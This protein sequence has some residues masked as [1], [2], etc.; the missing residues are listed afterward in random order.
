MITKL[1]LLG[2]GDIAIRL[3]NILSNTEM[4]CYGMRRDISKL[5]GNIEGIQQDFTSLRGFNRQLEKGFDVVVITLVPS[6]RSEEAYRKMYVESLE[7]M[8]R[9]L[10]STTISPKFVLFVS[11]TS[12]YAQNKG[13][14]ISELSPTSPVT[15]SGQCIQSAETCILSSRLSSTVV[16][17]SGIYGPGRRRL[18]QQVIDGDR[19]ENDN[20][21]SNRIHAD[22]C[23]EVLGHLIKKHLNDQTL[24]K[25][26]LATDCQPVKTKQVKQWLA[27]TMGLEASSSQS[28]KKSRKGNSS[29]SGIN[30]RCSNK[31]LLDSGFKFSHPTYK[32]GYTCLLA[33]EG[34]LKI[35]SSK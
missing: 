1:L 11:S 7:A 14:W 13:E 25:I 3:A 23:A 2:C 16:R 27:G 24:E 12:V 29:I 15:Y 28:L 10:E 30:K 34:L 9:S 6:E 20:G 5:P 17:F 21:F 32:D 22:D 33:E 4:K 8:V 35:G 26:Y 18:I 31:R 19:G